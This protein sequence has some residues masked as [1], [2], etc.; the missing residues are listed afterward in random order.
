METNVI[1]FVKK[2]KTISYT[3][4]NILRNYFEEI[5][6]NFRHKDNIVT[7]LLPVQIWKQHK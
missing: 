4:A 2:F 1:F 3:L 6:Q 7:L 5:I